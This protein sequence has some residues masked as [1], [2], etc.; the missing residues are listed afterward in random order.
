MESNP[1]TVPAISPWKMICFDVL[2]TAPRAFVNMASIETLRERVPE[3]HALAL[4]SWLSM[5]SICYENIE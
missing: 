1:A 5:N 4:N 3:N 2:E